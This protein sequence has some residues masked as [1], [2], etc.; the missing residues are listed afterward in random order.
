MMASTVNLFS[1]S[2]ISL[3]LIDLI[4]TIVSMENIVSASI[5]QLLI[6]VHL[7]TGIGLPLVILWR[8]WIYNTSSGRENQDHL[9][10]MMPFLI[11]WVL[12]AVVYFTRTILSLST[13]SSLLPL[14]GYLDLAATL[15]QAPQS[16]VTYITAVA[17]LA[18]LQEDQRHRK[19]M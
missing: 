14:V 4:I 16:F 12:H 13:S 2:F 6:I 19:S 7:F 18:P 10:Y 3:I 15:L 9:S 5:Q 8:V 17:H 1:E 11:T